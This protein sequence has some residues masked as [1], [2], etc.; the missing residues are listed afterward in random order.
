MLAKPGTHKETTKDNDKRP[1]WDERAERRFVPSQM[2]SVH[3]ED[4]RLA[5]CFGEYTFQHSGQLA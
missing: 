2:R 5:S 4:T 1:L 3:V